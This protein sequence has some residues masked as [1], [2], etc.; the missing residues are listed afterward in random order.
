[1]NQTGTHSEV[2][3]VGKTLRLTGCGDE[4]GGLMSMICIS[5]GGGGSEAR[6]AADLGLG[7]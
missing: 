7:P 6:R 5:D 4:G 3:M 2:R 1:M